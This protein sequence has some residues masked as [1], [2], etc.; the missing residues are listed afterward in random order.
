MCININASHS[1]IVI[2]F[3]FLK[4][5]VTNYQFS[6]IR[7]II[8]VCTS[9]HFKSC[10]F[11]NTYWEIFWKIYVN[12]YRIPKFMRK[13]STNV[14]TLLTL[15]EIISTLSIKETIETSDNSLP[16]KF[17]FFTCDKSCTFVFAY[18]SDSLNIWPSSYLWFPAVVFKQETKMKE[19]QDMYIYIYICQYA[20]QWKFYLSNYGRMFYEIW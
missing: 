20:D 9:F 2:L 8:N 10:F 6:Y 5:C 16:H 1:L 11:V 15:N 4:K 19:E 7:R 17:K 14:F 13:K 3:F 12:I 18:T